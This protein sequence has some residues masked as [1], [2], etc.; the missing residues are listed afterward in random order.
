[1]AYGRTASTSTPSTASAA[2]IS[3]SGRVPEGSSTTMSST[4]TPEPR[5]TTSTLRISASTPPRALAT[6]P[7]VPGVSGTCT[8]IRN[9]NEN[10]SQV[11]CCGP[12]G[13]DCG[14]PNI[15]VVAAPQGGHRIVAKTIHLLDTPELDACLPF[16]VTR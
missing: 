10:P 13:D 11:C 6:A 12:P 16:L 3:T 1:P 15:R 14:R 8:R 9:D 4:A 5:S 2:V 7:R